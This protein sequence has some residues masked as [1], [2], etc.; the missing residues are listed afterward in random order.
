MRARSR[1]TYRVDVRVRQKVFGPLGK[2]RTSER[3]NGRARERA[4]E[5]TSERT[6][7]QV[8]K[9][10]NES[11]RCSLASRCT[12]RTYIR[13]AERDSRSRNEWFFWYWF[14]RCHWCC[15]AGTAVP[16]LV[17]SLLLRM[18]RRVEKLWRNSNTVSYTPISNC[19]R[20]K[21]IIIVTLYFCL[22]DDLYL[23]LTIF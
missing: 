18:F 21:D 15:A 11:C 22:S 19:F 2:E 10:E 16:S 20:P 12:Y 14:C 17:P 3:E 23:Y 7:G 9:E 6:G 8:E 1:F 13:A 5:R 4:S